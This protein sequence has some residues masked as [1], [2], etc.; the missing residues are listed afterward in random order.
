MSSTN[1]SLMLRSTSELSVDLSACT[2]ATDPPDLICTFVNIII[3]IITTIII[4][5]IFSIMDSITILVK[6]FITEATNPLEHSNIFINVIV[7]FW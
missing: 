4:A 1:S 7:I 5:I 2:E 3:L 6:M